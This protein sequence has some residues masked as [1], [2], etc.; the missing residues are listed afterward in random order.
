M[1]IR[2]MQIILFL[3]FSLYWLKCYRSNE[4]ILLY[5]KLVSSNMRD[6]KEHFVDIVR[7]QN[8]KF[9]YAAKV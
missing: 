4:A 9:A 5:E 6:M 8:N 3:S 1:H 7:N 2:Y